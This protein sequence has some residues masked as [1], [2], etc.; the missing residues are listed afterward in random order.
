MGACITQQEKPEIAAAQRGITGSG[1]VRFA[2]LLD[3]HCATDEDS[4]VLTYVT[5]DR[6]DILPPG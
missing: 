4:D 1:A 6:S 3:S 2:E 5:A